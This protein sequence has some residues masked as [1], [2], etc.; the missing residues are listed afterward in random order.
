MA[1]TSSDIQGLYI[2]YF[3]RPADYLGLQFW[4]DAANKAGGINTVANAF[5]A[6]P[7]YTTAFANKGTAE[8]IDQI[9][10][11]LFGRHAEL[12]GIKFWGNALDNKILGIGNIAYQIMKGAQDTEGGFQ[13]KTAVASKISAATAFYNSLDTAAEVIGYSGDAANAVVKTW[14]AGVTD[15]ASLDAATTDAALNAITA[16]AVA[17]HDAI[18]NAGTDFI[19]TT[20]V[21]AFTGGAGNDTFTA[22]NTVNGQFSAADTLNGGAGDDSLTI[23]GTTG[24]VTVAKVSNIEHITVD[25]MVDTAAW[26]LSTVIGA[27]DVTVSR[28]AGDATVT[29]AAGV[30]V[31]LF[32]NVNAAK[33]E[34]V[35][36]SATQTSAK[37]NLDTVVGTVDVQ[38]AAI[39]TLNVNTSNAAST[40]AALTTAAATTTINVTGS[41]N[42]TV[43][44]NLDNEVSKV[45]AS[46]FTGK[47]NIS[48]GAVADDGT[49]AVDLTIIGGTN[50]DTLSIVGETDAAAKTSVNAGAG[51]DTVKVTAI[52]I[53]TDALDT[54]NGGA[55]TDVLSVDYAATATALTTDLSATVSG[56]ESATLTSSAGGG[57]QTFVF[58]EGTAKTG[59]G[60]F[61]INGLD[62]ADSFSITGLKAA[63]TVTVSSNQ[64]GVA[65]AINTDTTADTVSF[66]LD[67]TTLTG[68]LTATNYETVNIASNKD[69]SD[70]TNSLASVAAS[71][72]KTVNLT[73]S[74]ALVGGTVTLASGATFNAAAYTG[75]LTATTFGASVKSYV[76][77]SGK[78]QITLAAGDLK[79][80]NT[81]AGGAG[82]SDKLTVTAGASQDMGILGL[83]GFETVNLTTSG[84]NV[85]DFRNVTDLATLNVSTGAGTDDLTLN[86]L[87]S[88]T[89]VTFHTAIDQ[90][91][92]TINSGTT[93]KVGFDAAI[94]VASL[95]L[96][97]GTT[98]LTV[99]SDNG[100]ATADE[101]GGSFTAISGTSLATINVTGL[102]RTNLGTLSTT[103]TKVDASAA[104]GGLTVTASATATSI[105]GSQAADAI[106]G[107]GAA[108]TIEGGKGADTISGG[109][110]HDT[111][112]F[113]ATGAANGT[114]VLTVTFGSGASG[115]ILSFKNFL[116]GG[117]VDQNSGAG[118]AI[119]AYS[120][121]ATTDVNIAGHAVTL[122]DATGG[123]VITAVDSAAEIAALIQGS[124]NV[125]SL[126]S[127]GKAV[128]I[129]GEST[130]AAGA[131]IYFVDDSLDGV[132][133]TVT[134]TDVTIV[135]TIAA[136]TDIDAVLTSNITFS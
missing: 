128:I 68:A 54:L 126:T 11:N 27:K 55:G 76:G 40:L 28:A 82:A 22:D 12:D 73:G 81:F 109:A 61:K 106:T 51:D 24:G 30:D 93:Q 72:A 66:V 36:F 107:G 3:N 113:G 20:G 130:G 122:A 115:D 71:S 21:N 1:V 79:Q 83:T 95:T 114:D 47:L 41:Q 110:G 52:Q 85:A 16:S 100:N 50:N 43:T 75:D 69:S 26:N 15:Q 111:I 108:D 118:T 131:V 8:I 37:V 45:D 57:A 29:V 44:A 112:V 33:T 116:S 74:G 18:S 84:A 46:T 103:V 38:G 2:A 58:A 86:R 63:A 129:A 134:A 119:I 31:T 42:L 5:A 99:N 127:G 80:G 123:G 62:A 35:I 4:T 121:G 78:D 14:L 98:T 90:V 13:D 49:T 96:D 60:A 39:A 56:F 135:G 120:S 19:L 132:A 105:I 67:G 70:N 34:T 64:V 77:G 136:A 89:Q 17:A 7:E 94:A 23:Y 88:T 10:M 25:S 32:S 124:G 133:G 91:V 6:S 101:A 97:S 104:T 9:Y 48:A 87:A 102:D 65:A 117:S 92:T 125:F 53:A 59:L